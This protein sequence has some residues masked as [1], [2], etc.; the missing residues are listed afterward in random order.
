MRHP[1]FCKLRKSKPEVDTEIK[2]VDVDATAADRNR[3]GIPRRLAKR[4]RYD[5]RHGV[6]PGP[7]KAIRVVEAVM[8]LAVRPRAAD[9]VTRVILELHRKAGQTQRGRGTVAG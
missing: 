6:I 2:V 3:A 8:A 9:H 7:A 5:H 4:R 1:S